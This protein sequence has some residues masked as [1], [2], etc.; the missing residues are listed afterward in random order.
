M[1]DKSVTKFIYLFIYI[2]FDISYPI[3]VIKKRSTNKRSADEQWNKI[4]PVMK[5]IAIS[6]HQI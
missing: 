3:P 1:S 5:I 4:L 6:N 2:T